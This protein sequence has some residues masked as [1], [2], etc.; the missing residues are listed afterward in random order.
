MLDTRVELDLIGYHVHVPWLLGKYS[1]S[2]G[3]CLDYMQFRKT[4]CT[5][6]MEVT[7]KVYNYSMAAS[8]IW[9]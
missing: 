3:S 2:N 1:I 9:H 7:L 6:S 4:N 8:A 5:L